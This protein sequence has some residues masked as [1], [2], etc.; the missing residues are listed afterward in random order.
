[1]KKVKAM[2][3]V[4]RQSILSL[5]DK[6]RKSVPLSCNDGLGGVILESR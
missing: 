4:L 6:E 2:Q 3:E 5:C 1:M